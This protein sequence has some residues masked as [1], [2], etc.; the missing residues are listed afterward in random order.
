M[1]AQ[2]STALASCVD[3]SSQV[4]TGIAAGIRLFLGALFVYTGLLKLYDPPGFLDDLYQYELL[5]E[6]AGFAVAFLVPVIELAFGALLLAGSARR[7]ALSG[8]AVLL[9]VFVMAQ[10]SAMSRGLVIDCA[11]FGDAAPGG[12]L[13]GPWS[14]ARTTALALLAGVAL[15]LDGAPKVGGEKLQ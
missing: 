13:V 15:L 14:I 2:T 12:A 4:R 8:A 10:G 11:C 7:V 3:R 1:T 9:L 5:G 6:R